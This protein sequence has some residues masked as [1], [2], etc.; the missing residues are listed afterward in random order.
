MI[1]GLNPWPSAYA[2]YGGKFLKIWDADVLDEAQAGIGADAVPGT[3]LKAS[4]SDL[5]IRTG[6]GIL[7]IRELQT[8]GKK[9]MDTAA[10]LRGH[11]IPEGTILHG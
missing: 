10:F 2:R 9:R 1:R 6:E 8:E 7:A 3:V 11:A 4:G 5:W